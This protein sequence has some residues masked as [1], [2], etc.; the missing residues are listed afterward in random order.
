[1]PI[2]KTR[3]EGGAKESKCFTISILDLVDSAAL[4]TENH[5]SLALGRK[6]D[7]FRQPALSN[8]GHWPKFC[9]DWPKSRKTPNRPSQN[10]RVHLEK[11][12]YAAFDN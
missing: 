3:L 7:K 11:A 4:L 6:S 1:V 12:G 9:I 10:C 5:F 2:G 8:G